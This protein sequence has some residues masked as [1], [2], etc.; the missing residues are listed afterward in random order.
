MEYITKDILVA[1]IGVIKDE[2]NKLE[3][4]KP[5]SRKYI[6]PECNKREYIMYNYAEW[7]CNYLKNKMN[8]GGLLNLQSTIQAL[9]HT[10]WLHKSFNHF[11]YWRN[12]DL[13][14][15]LLKDKFKYKDTEN[16]TAQFEML[17]EQAEYLVRATNWIIGTLEG[18]SDFG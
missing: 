8:N 18:I 3:E 12:D 7:L 5:R 13:S 15:M 2:Q 6:V 4:Y 11:I 17:K 16:L 1:M 14:R 9:R 10:D